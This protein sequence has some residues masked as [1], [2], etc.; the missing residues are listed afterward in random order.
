[1]NWCRVFS[2]LPAIITL[3][4]LG[5]SVGWD[6]TACSQEAQSGNED[7]VEVLVRGPV[8]E[9]FAQTVTFN[10]EPGIVVS[11]APPD[12]IEELPP[13][14]RPEGDNVS[15]I[16]GYWAWDDDRDDFLW[17]SGIWR[18]LPP[19]RQWVPGYWSQAG[20]KVQWTSGY[21]ADATRSENE[22]LPEPPDTVE[23]GPN[24]AAPSAG[25]IWT[26]G[27]W[28][29]NE[30]RYAWRPG[31]WVVAQQNWVWVP[32]QYLWS[33]RGYVFVDGYYDYSV[34][35][36]GVIF[37]PVYFNQNVY[38]RQGFTY[39]PTMAISLAV[40][41]NQLFLRPNYNH[42]YYGDYY[43]SSYATAGFYPWFSFNSGRRGYDPFY[44]QQ[45]WQ[46]RNDREWQQRVEADYQHR[47][48]HE[49][50]R[51]PRTLA[52]QQTLIKTGNTTIVNN[53]VVATSLDQM[54]KSKDAPV[55]FQAVNPAEKE[56]L[57]NHGND[58][59]KFRS[60]RQK[61]EA[62]PAE[63]TGETPA[64]DFKP[65]RVKLP[66]SPILA[67]SSDQLDK[68]DAPP[69]RLEA[70]MPDLKVEPKPR[71]ADTRVESPKGEPK[72]PKAGT[73]PE[74]PQGRPKD[75]PKVEPK[76]VPRDPLKATPKD[77]PKPTPKVERQPERPKVEPKPIP[78][79][80][81]KPDPR[82]EPKPA[83]RTEPKP[84]PKVEP[85]PMPRVEPK[86]TPKVE[87]RPERPKVEPK[88]APKV[89]PKREPPQ[90]KPRTKDKPKDDDKPKK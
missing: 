79:D 49:E 66:A 89:E 28:V 78:K 54:T 33:P 34:A 2:N 83:P 5:A 81:P 48:D 31:Y 3:A 4:V 41:G 69:K 15:W 80:E 12:S 55:R 25:H 16:P 75:E 11:R 20:Q 67:K 58:V 73:I 9:A 45:R 17:V 56:K 52:A 86:P 77:E 71:R 23:V 60:E 47:R 14:Q 13:D 44:A 68:D 40:F 21:W 53:I 7:G 35:R 57:V 61:L 74:R 36:R 38:A 64:K 19:G 32:A 1:M 90:D 50:S 87:P 82:I 85:K 43:G 30:N 24:I 65:T 59:R 70:P 10:P 22:Y 63:T 51:P 39:S 29:W 37:A 8:H 88:P 72:T 84:V 42:Y 46:N 6:R 62:K 76:P 27:C 26:P 18:A